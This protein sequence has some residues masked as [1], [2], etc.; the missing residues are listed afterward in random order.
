[1][2]NEECEQQIVELLG[3]ISHELFSYSRRLVRHT[4]LTRPQLAA[5]L[6]LLREGEASSGVLARRLSLSAPTLSGVLDRLE[7][8]ALVE[9]RRGAR[10]RRAVW[11]RPTPAAQR[12]PAEISLLGTGFSARLARLPDGEKRRIVESLRQLAGLLGEPS[13]SRTD[14]G[15]GTD[16]SPPP[17]V[18]S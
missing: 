10:D 3:Q 8:K 16:P 18:G 2:V 15:S 14:G 9:R 1:M 12:L 4:G 13:Q 6:I 5:M 7:E 11:V 17:F